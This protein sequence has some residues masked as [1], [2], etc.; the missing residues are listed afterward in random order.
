V[1]ASTWNYQAQY[2]FE[3]LLFGY[4]IIFNITFYL[5]AQSMGGTMFYLEAQSKEREV[6][7]QT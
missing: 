3:I 1:I 6:K 7:I 5:E 4:P 2:V